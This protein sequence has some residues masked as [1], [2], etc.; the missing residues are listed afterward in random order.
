MTQA[1]RLRLTGFLRRRVRQPA[2]VFAIGHGMGFVVVGHWWQA[3]EGTADGWALRRALGRNGDLRRPG[4]RRHCGR[5]GVARRAPS[6]IQMFS[7]RGDSGPLGQVG[8]SY[9]SMR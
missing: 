5:G 6:R 4:S 2:V 9:L 1:L 7:L 3:D 8:S